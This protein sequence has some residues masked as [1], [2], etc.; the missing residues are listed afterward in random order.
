M[1]T[2]TQIHG[3]MVAT[4]DRELEALLSV[5]DEL[6][7][8]EWSL[9]TRLNLGRGPGWDVLTAVIHIGIS[10][11]MLPA[12]VAE[13]A[14]GK[15]A[16]EIT[17]VTHFIFDVNKFAPIVD[18]L[19][20]DAAQGATPRSTLDALRKTVGATIA[21]ARE[22][23]P[24]FIG[25]AFF[26]TMRLDDVLPT[27]VLEAAVHGLD[28][29]DA[30]G[31]EPHLTAGARDVTVHLLEELFEHLHH[32]ER[33]ASLTDPITFIEVATGRRSNQDPRFPIVR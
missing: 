18:T 7:P 14:I 9:E 24:D 31:R 15:T 33:P 16:P 6:T 32:E 26:G 28:L 22:T 30:L 1:R 25:K 5:L 19:A 10:M 2:E 29:S 11:S 21:A 8:K 12:V 3:Q 13:P 4:L 20:R 27:R 23:P 17:R